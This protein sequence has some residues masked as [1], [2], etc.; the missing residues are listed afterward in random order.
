MYLYVY[1]STRFEPLSSP[2]EHASPKVLAGTLWHIYTRTCVHKS[3]H[4]NVLTYI[5]VYMIGN[6]II[7]HR[8]N[9]EY[10]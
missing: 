4:I 7:T 10:M 5:P 1:L 6:A 3:I 9:R 8:T 2:K